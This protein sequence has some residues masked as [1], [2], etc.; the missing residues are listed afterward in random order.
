MPLLLRDS[1]CTIGASGD[2]NISSPEV[3][4]VLT[5]ARFGARKGNGE[6]RTFCGFTFLAIAILIIAIGALSTESRLAAPRHSTSALHHTSRTCRLAEGSAY[7]LAPVN[8]ENEN[9]AIPVVQH[10]FTPHILA[11]EFPLLELTGAPQAHG[12]R[13][14]PR[15]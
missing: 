13:A 9:K 6:A 1:W 4:R 12:L 7:E 11:L 3:N 2:L 5:M 10:E 8:R 14:P 15:A